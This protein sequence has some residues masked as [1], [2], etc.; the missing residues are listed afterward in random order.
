MN[1]NN[2]K[3]MNPD[4]ATPFA[5]AEMSGSKFE[6]PAQCEGDVTNVECLI[7]A[8][9]AQDF[10]C[11]QLTVAVGDEEYV[12][13]LKAGKAEYC[14]VEN[15]RHFINGPQ[16]QPPKDG[17]FK[18]SGFYDM[19][20]FQDDLLTVNFPW[21]T[22]TWNEEG[23]TQLTGHRFLFDRDQVFEKDGKTPLMHAKGG[24][25]TKL[26]VTKYIGKSDGT[27]SAMST[28]TTA[29]S[30]GG[31]TEEEKA[32]IEETVLSLL[33]TPKKKTEV[34]V[35]VKQAHGNDAMRLLS[36]PWAS[37]SDRPWKVEKGIFSI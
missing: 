19:A 4:Y 15:G 20:R 2:T 27:K 28:T 29:A 3:T 22:E 36:T 17:Q 31:V 6:V 5:H 32:A 25:V 18:V 24:P 30:N 35:A 21:N 7:K 13:D 8:I 33:D 10:A 9:G 26:R 11:L 16:A 23:Y 34:Q 12:E 37:S 14:S 1:Q